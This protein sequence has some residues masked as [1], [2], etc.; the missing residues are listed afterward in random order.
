[1]LKELNIRTSV[2]SVEKYMT[3]CEEFRNP[4]VI[5]FT[6]FKYWWFIWNLN[7]FDRT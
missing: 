6:I 4:I 1:M 3:D 7:G 5:F 2:F